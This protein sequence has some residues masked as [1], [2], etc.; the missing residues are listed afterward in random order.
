MHYGYGKKTRNASLKKKKKKSSQS[1][2]PRRRK[3][4]YPVN[5]LPKKTLE[6]GQ[7]F[8]VVLIMI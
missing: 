6:I 7:P 1:G 8:S 2:D 3:P 5:L 4:R